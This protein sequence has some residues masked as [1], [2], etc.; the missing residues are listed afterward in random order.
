[1]VGNAT[2]G[3]GHVA[4]EEPS[5]GNPAS[6][7]GNVAGSVRRPYGSSRFLASVAKARERRAR[8][9]READPKTHVEGESE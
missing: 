7:S 6:L 2:H 1:M 9:E 8:R 4:T 5:G 3:P